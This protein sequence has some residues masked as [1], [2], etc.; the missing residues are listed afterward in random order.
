MRNVRGLVPITKR[1]QSLRFRSAKSLDPEACEAKGSAAQR[2]QC[3]AS[4]IQT[5]NVG[6]GVASPS[7]PSNAAKALQF[8]CVRHSAM[9]PTLSYLS[10]PLDAIS[11]P[12]FTYCRKSDIG[13]HHE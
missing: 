9:V 5:G 4:E 6:V 1:R 12:V 8:R 7:V 10:V 2:G 13:A 3:G 11:V